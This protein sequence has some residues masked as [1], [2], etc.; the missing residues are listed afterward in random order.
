[1][2]KIQQ[3]VKMAQLQWQRKDWRGLLLMLGYLLPVIGIWAIAIFAGTD[4]IVHPQGTCVQVSVDGGWTHSLYANSAIILRWLGVLLYVAAGGLTAVTTDLIRMSQLTSLKRLTLDEPIEANHGETIEEVIRNIQYEP[5]E[6]LAI[7]DPDGRK[8]GEMTQ[9]N[10]N[11]VRPGNRLWQY[12]R[13][14]PGCI[15]VHNHPQSIIGFSE[16]DFRA[17]MLS[18]ASKTI[19]IAETMVYTLELPDDLTNDEAEGAHRYYEDHWKCS[20]LKTLS[21]LTDRVRMDIDATATIMLCRH[22]AEMYDMTFTAEP[23][24]TSAYAKDLRKTGAEEIPACAKPDPLD[25]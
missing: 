13:E 3:I 20:N 16:K 15:Q 6:Y 21:R 12:M 18:K 7:F 14:H 2:R 19:V 5:V 23:Y 25:K 4:A 1:M 22:I 10:P 24:E 9:L 11:E 17:A 8:V